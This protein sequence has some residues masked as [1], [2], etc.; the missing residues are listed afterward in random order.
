MSKRSKATKPR[1]PAQGVLEGVDASLLDIVDHVLTKGIVLTGDLVLG[2]ADIDLIYLR[3][4]A[5]LCAADRILGKS[6]DSAK[7]RARHS[8]R[9][10]PAIGRGV[11][12][13]KLGT[14]RIGSKR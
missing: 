10:A 1:A 12:A 13:R 8:E 9:T 7:R 5:V 4:S 14:P 2:V 3:L 11:I 6:P